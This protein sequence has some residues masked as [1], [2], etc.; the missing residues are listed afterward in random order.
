MTPFYLN[1]KGFSLIEYVIALAVIAVGLS[2]FFLVVNESVVRSADPMSVTQGNSIAESYLEEVLLSS[3]CDPDFST[4]CPT[5]CDA[6]LISGSSICVECSIG[7]E[8]RDNYD[9]ICDYDAIN[10]TSGAVDR[11]GN[12]I[13]GLEDYNV[14][15]EVVDSGVDLNGL[16]SANAAALR[17][18]VTVTHDNFSDL[19]ISLSGYKANF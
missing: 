15:I 12:T 5:D 2:G 6:T 14:E 4:D 10:D 8:T 13:S 18:D 19:N 9:D 1:T 11:N 16:T 7:G 17:I 3:F